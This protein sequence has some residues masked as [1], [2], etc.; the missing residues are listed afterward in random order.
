MRMRARP[1]G[2]VDEPPDTRLLLEL[3]KEAFRQQ[4]AKRVRPLARSYAERWMGCERW[5]YPS[6]IQG[7]GNELHSYKP[8]VIEPLR[9]TSF[10]EILPICRT[11]HPDPDDI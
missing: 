10:N 8:A 5:L 11:P 9:K 2:M 1:L 3:A 6:V 4:V 7:N